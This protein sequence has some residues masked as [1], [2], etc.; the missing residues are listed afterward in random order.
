MKQ[1]ARV[2][3]VNFVVVPA[4]FDCAAVSEAGRLSVGRRRCQE[5]VPSAAVVAADSV[6]KERTKVDMCPKFA[7]Y[8]FKLTGRLGLPTID[9][10]LDLTAQR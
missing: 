9:R 1:K 10:V 7:L 6:A 4:K 2:N 8:A 3:F 5:T